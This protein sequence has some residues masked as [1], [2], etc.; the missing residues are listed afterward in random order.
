[1]FAAD[2]A[3]TVLDTDQG[4]VTVTYTP[5]GEAG[6]SIPAFFVPSEDDLVGL[7]DGTKRVRRAR[8]GISTEAANGVESPSDEDTVTVDGT[9]WQIDD[10]HV[11]GVAAL[12]DLVR[13]EDVE[14][15]GPDHRRE[16]P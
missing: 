5:D 4:A 7:E 11:D 9:V 3:A 15:S 14:K 16:M 1:M 2:M 10:V 8:M 12:L 6:V 13:Y